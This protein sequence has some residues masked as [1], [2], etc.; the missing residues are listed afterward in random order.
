MNPA[1]CQHRIDSLKLSE[2]E[3]QNYSGPQSAF[4]QEQLAAI[5]KQIGALEK[6]QKLCQTPKIVWVVRMEEPYYCCDM[7]PL[8]ETRAYF[9]DELKAR[10]FANLISMADPYYE[11]IRIDREEMY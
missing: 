9:D 6:I 7:G 10:E 3:Y 8:S 4:V 11:T 5:S 1:Y 2:T